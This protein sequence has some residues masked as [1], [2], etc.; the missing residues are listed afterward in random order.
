M[1]SVLQRPRL[2]GQRFRLSRLE[3]RAASGLF[4]VF[5]LSLLS[6]PRPSFAQAAEAAPEAEEPSGPVEAQVQ[7]P[8]ESGEESS[9]AKAPEQS[10]VNLIIFV[11]DA[12][13]Q[14]A[15]VGINDGSTGP[16]FSDENGAARLSTTT[17]GKVALWV[18]LPR[19]A[20]PDA[21]PGGEPLQIPLQEIELVPGETVEVIATL[22]L[23]GSVVSVD[24]EAVAG[25]VQEARAAAES[26][27]EADVSVGAVNGQ[28]R[29]SEKNQPVEGARIFVKGSSVE[30]VSNAAGQFSL[31]LP[32][33]KW[34]ISVIHPDYTTATQPDV[35]VS[36]DGQSE[37]EFQLLPA[38]VV[39]EDFVITVPHVEGSVA[40]VLNERR[41]SAAMSDAVSAEDISKSGAGD[42]AGAAQ[43]V[44]G[45]TIVDGK[46]VYV[47]G[48]GERYTNSL[49][50]GSPMPSPEPDKATVPLDL[51]PTQVIKSID[52][53][54]TSTPDFP[55]DFAGG[56]V[57]I[58][59]ITVPE[60]PIFGISL[61]TG[62]NSQSTFRERP[63][64]PTGS[65]D[66]LG[67]DDG[68]RRL[69]DSAPPDYFL[70]RGVRKPDDER[71]SREEVTEAA[72]DFNT[73]VTPHEKRNL[74][75][76][77]GSIIWGRSFPLGE[78]AKLGTL[79]SLT[80][81][82]KPTLRQE[83]IRESRPRDGDLIA[84]IDGEATT[85]TDTVR[86]GAF[87]SVALEFLENHEISLIG[88]RS[89]IADDQTRH[90]AFFHTNND[91]NYET[92]RNEYTSRS[93]EFAQLRGKHTF[94]ITF[95]TQ[96]D[97]RLSLGR[98]LL[99]RPDTRDVVYF[100]G[101][102]SENFSYAPG[103]ESGRHFYADMVENSR[104]AY[105]DVT[106][107]IVEGDLE[108]K[109]KLG[110]GINHRGRL[111]KARRFSFSS[112]DSDASV[113]GPEFDV[114]CPEDLF[115][116]EN[117]E[118]GVLVLQEDTRDTDAYTAVADV[119][120]GYAMAD[121][122]LF[123]PLRFIGGVRVEKTDQVVSAYNQFDPEDDEGPDEGRFE[124][125]DLLPS[126]AVVYA[127]TEWL[128]FRAAGSRTVA[129]PQ[130][131]EMGPFSFSDYFGGATVNGNPDLVHTK[132][133]NADLRADIFPSPSEVISFSVFAKD[134]TDPI[135]PVLIPGA[136]QAIQTFSNANGAFL[137][138]LELE[139]R[140]DLAFVSPMLEYFG[141]MGNLTLATS[142]IDIEQTGIDASGEVG[143]ITTT[144]RPMVNQA[145]Y[146]I[147]LALDFEV[148]DQTQMR[149]LYNVSG[150]QIVAIGT[151][152]LSDA[153]LQPR[154]SL[155]FTFSQPL[156][157]RLKLGGSVNN[158][159]N[160]LYL[161]TQGKE[162]DKEKMTYG[163]RTGVSVGVSLGYS[164]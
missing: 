121:F 137:Y 140:K 10:R 112:T 40:S 105:F 114:S 13:V 79:A 9:E 39:L 24:A 125:T 50:N 46:F 54:K 59:T 139:A 3:A 80:Y 45:V 118:N 158:I 86:W 38:S 145:P 81:S 106:Q 41:E 53:A 144:E 63:A 134:F 82:R 52:I 130:L 123:K 111:F 2:K 77:G 101:G 19:D 70:R 89:Q 29:D 152:G 58:E 16:V 87:G 161:V 34:A 88:L 74:P 36:A 94:P 51:L 64:F 75:D 117:I 47:R 12:P 153:Y 136:S 128:E 57:R 33:G 100:K 32:E 149:L 5:L 8:S 115:T 60:E 18:R 73:P 90:F 120:A 1:N 148:P 129:R 124:S 49:L 119:L 150:K 6:A 15:E 135:E 109:F 14:G 48:L 104:A 96:L 126:A 68:M 98:A 162:R 56:S 83:I 116:D 133:L 141:V 151:S 91:G 28:I 37:V 71:V 103:T 143:F 131:R 99:A 84:G 76:L 142:K 97:W 92:I 78:D 160:S 42:A 122:K 44:V 108:K 110:G 65:T 159:L 35:A 66:F 27:T 102:S 85:A 132:I 154:H 17:R 7:E 164:L 69:P 156:T 20:A 21:P 157:E 67:F 55:A 43:R 107:P 147:N 61:K 72:P 138:G 93:L 11:G 31:E 23:D 113:C 163:Y 95:N 62:Y 146:V 26:E 4:F 25:S 22:A 127:M 30:A 155:D